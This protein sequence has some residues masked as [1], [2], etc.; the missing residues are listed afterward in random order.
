MQLMQ[1]IGQIS[2]MAIVSAC[3]GATGAILANM[4][5]LIMI[6]KINSCVPD[7]ERI[8]YIWWGGEVRGRFRKLFPNSNFIFAFDACRVMMIIGFIG[9]VKFWVFS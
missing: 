9:I 6:G 5:S 2:W 1:L 3:I 8:S 7:S 4:I